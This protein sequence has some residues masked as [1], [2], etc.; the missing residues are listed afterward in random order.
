MAD[1]MQL[2]AKFEKIL[3]GFRATSKCQK[4]HNGSEPTECF[5]ALHKVALYHAYHNSL[6]KIGYQE[7]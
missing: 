7:L 2:F 3:S 5:W 6:I 4:L 1:M